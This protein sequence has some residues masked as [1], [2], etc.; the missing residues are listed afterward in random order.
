[1]VLIGVDDPVTGRANLNRAFHGIE[2]GTLHVALIH[3]P[4]SFPSLSRRG[5]DIAFSGHT[6]GGQVRIPIVGPLPLTKLFE[7]IIDS[8]DRFGFIGLV[9][10]GMG[11]QP[12]ARMRLFCRP[13][14]VLVHIEGA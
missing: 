12:E 2:N 8:T 7:P 13:E 11:A 5:I 1:M 4:A 14:A 6:H 9:S 10:R 3:S